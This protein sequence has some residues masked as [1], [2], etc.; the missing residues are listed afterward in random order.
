MS[1]DLPDTTGYPLE[2]ARELLQ[3][4][5]VD[6]VDVVRVGTLDERAQDRRVMVIR[7]RSGDDG[8]VELT[9]ASE[10]RTPMRQEG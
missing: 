4:A 1:T 3:A 2:K 7:Q 9:V 10:W 5:G 8:A 6:A